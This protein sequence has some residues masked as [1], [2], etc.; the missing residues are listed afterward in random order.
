VVG[1]VFAAVTA[2]VMVIAVL[3]VWGHVAKNA[4]QQGS[5]AAP[6]TMAARR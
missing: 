5:L 4:T 1:F 3:V 6:A 2:M